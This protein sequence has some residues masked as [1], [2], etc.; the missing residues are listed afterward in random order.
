ME[1]IMARTLTPDELKA[2]ST[3]VSRLTK[4]DV[5]ILTS[6]GFLAMDDDGDIIAFESIMGSLQIHFAANYIHISNDCL[7][8]YNM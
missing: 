4:R 5:F 1:A 7:H 2:L 6:L 8:V 3:S